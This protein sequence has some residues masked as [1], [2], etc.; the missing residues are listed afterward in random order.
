MDVSLLTESRAQRERRVALDP[1]SVRSL[2]RAGHTVRVE[3]GA[4]EAAGFPDPAYEDAG[5][6]VV[7]RRLEALGR[8]RLVLSLGWLSPGDLGALR[9]DA[10]VV[11]L[12]RLDLAPAAVRAATRSSGATCVSADRLR[13]PSGHLPVLERM[14]ELAGALAP[15]LAARLLESRAPGRHGVLL[16]AL[17]GLPPPEVVIL[18]AGTLGASAAHAF[19]ALGLSVHLLDASLERLEVLFPDLPPNVFTAVASPERVATMGAFANVLV[20]AVRDGGTRAPVVVPD[21][22][23]RGMRAGSVLLDFSIDAGGG[24]AT[25]RPISDPA[26]AY[27]VH[28]VLHLSMPNTPTLV[29]RTATRRLSH[30]LLPFVRQLA[31]GAAPK[32]HPTF[33]PA[34]WWGEEAP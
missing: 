15:Q 25:S 17:P 10:M 3:R 34:V 12:H 19:G 1:R 29:A 13:D 24:A 16:A 21:A 33:S 20:V 2:V 5:A 32:A 11:N 6:T 9:D 7:H 30:A 8:G 26:D 18:G 28:G 4:G 27:T 14:S 22:V 31:D 23:V